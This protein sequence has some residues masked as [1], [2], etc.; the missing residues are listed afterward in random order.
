MRAVIAALI[1]AAAGAT[2]QAQ[3][4]KG[5]VGFGAGIGN[6]PDL[7]S[8]TPPASQCDDAPFAWKFFAGYMFLPYIGIEGGFN[9]FGAAN[10]QGVLLN[11]PPGTVPLPSNA[12][13]YTQVWSLSVV[14]RIPI[15]AAAIMGRVG[16]G[17]VISKTSGL[18]QVLD[19]QTG[20]ITNYDT[21]TSGD[22]RT[23]DLRRRHFAGTSCRRGP[24]ASTGIIPRATTVPT[25]TTTSTCTRSG[26]PI[27]SERHRADRQAPPRA[28]LCISAVTPRPT[29]GPTIGA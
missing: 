26:S 4:G 6:Y 9:D 8:Q 7:C 29:T 18:A 19:P 13:V 27:A 24:R 3:D 11:P 12:D 28:G 14:G 2:A 20:A 15:G 17:S 22:D 5:Y 21:S 25:R 23:D 10:T 16:Y 1:L